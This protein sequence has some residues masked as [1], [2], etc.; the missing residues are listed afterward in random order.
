MDK[1]FWLLRHNFYHNRKHDKLDREKYKSA[2]GKSV[3]D[4]CSDDLEKVGLCDLI[5]SS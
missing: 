3:N 5:Y 4:V 1:S 2:L